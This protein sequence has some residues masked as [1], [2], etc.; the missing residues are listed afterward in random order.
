[1][2]DGENTDQTSFSYY[3]EMEKRRTQIDNLRRSSKDKT[4]QI[5]KLQAQIDELEKG[6]KKKEKEGYEGKE[7]EK[8]GEGKKTTLTNKEKYQAWD[9]RYWMED[10]KEEKTGSE[11]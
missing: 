4:E 10:K 5:K 11:N 7:K 3:K 6:G 1:M 9:P 2:G 8:E